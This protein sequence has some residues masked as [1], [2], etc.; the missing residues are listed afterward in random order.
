MSSSLWP[1]SRNRLADFRCI[2]FPQSNAKEHRRQR[3][4]IYRL[5]PKTVRNVY[6]IPRGGSLVGKE[7]LLEIEEINGP[8]YLRHRIIATAEAPANEQSG[9]NDSEEQAE[10]DSDNSG[11]PPTWQTRV[12]HTE[13]KATEATEIDRDGE[14]EWLDIDD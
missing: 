4:K 8:R 2:L 13:I 11:E 9:T 7:L 12:T 1:T 6:R 3:T 14:S 10:Q 5:G